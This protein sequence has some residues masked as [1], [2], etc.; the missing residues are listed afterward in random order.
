M[1]T[2][3]RLKRTTLTLA[4]EFVLNAVLGELRHNASEADAAL[5]LHGLPPLRDLIGAPWAVE[6]CGPHASFVNATGP[7]T[8]CLRDGLSHPTRLRYTLNVER[9]GPDGRVRGVV[10]VRREYGPVQ[11]SAADPGGD[12][13]S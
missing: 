3:Y 6:W 11:V 12:L 1:T 7:V 4:D 9:P 8:L 2:P 5:R 13:Y 10:V